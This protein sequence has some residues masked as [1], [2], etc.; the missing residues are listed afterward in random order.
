MFHAILFYPRLS[1]SLCL[2][3]RSMSAVH[4]ILAEETY[5]N[6][7]ALFKSKYTNSEDKKRW[8]SDKSTLHDVENAL[9]AAKAKYE[10][11][12]SSVARKYINKVSTGIMYYS[13]I[14][15][16]LVQHH[17]EYVSLGWGTMKL[18]LVA[19]EPPNSEPSKRSPI[20]NCECSL[21]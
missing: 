14:M 13:N 6:A 15:D 12:T 21:C 19:F 16:M 11:R 7:A 3:T 2:S 18:I 8:L 4:L 10:A 5:R 9:L 17:P 1:E 20:S